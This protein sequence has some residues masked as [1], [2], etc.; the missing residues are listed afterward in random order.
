MANSA[1]E[2]REQLRKV[3]AETDLSGPKG[4]ENLAVVSPNEP[5]VMS[6]PSQ[7]TR[8]RPTKSTQ[9]PHSEVAEKGV[10]SCMLKAPTTVIPIV[11]QAVASNY[12]YLPTNQQ[13][14]SELCVFFTDEGMFDLP[15]FTQHL[16]DMGRI[17]QVGGPGYVTELAVDF[18]AIPENISYY[19]DILKDKHA[20]RQIIQVG[21]NAAQR[22]LELDEIRGDRGHI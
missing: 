17:G 11:Q 15:T 9:L 19:L 6:R 18:G 21:R 22:A 5:A 16:M 3:K 13:F 1:E 8:S 2:L 4:G 10:L 7:N 20:R 14:F 12:F